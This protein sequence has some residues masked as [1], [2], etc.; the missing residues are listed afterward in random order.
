MVGHFSGRLAPLHWLG[1][2]HYIIVH[3]CIVVV[4]YQT[5]VPGQSAGEAAFT[6]V[7]VYSVS[8]WGITTSTCYFKVASLACLIL[9]IDSYKLL[10]YH[11]CG[12]L[13][14]RQSTK[15]NP[16][17]RRFEPVVNNI[18]VLRNAVTVNIF[19]NFIIV[20]KLKHDG[21]LRSHYLK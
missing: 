13:T 7:S 19:F 4:L 20:T 3:V 17:T 12:P 1:A 8:R 2:I 15:A 18:H 21:P 10:T 9:S 14:K 5:T 11:L 16:I 6:S